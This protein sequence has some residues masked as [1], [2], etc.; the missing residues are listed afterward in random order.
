MA[1]QQDGPPPMW[2]IAAMT[3]MPVLPR[4]V[5]QLAYAG[6]SYAQIA[7]RLGLTYEVVRRAG[8]QAMSL[9]GSARR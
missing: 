3:V 4:T 9:L 2:F 1:R 8:H 6:R 5:L 7:G